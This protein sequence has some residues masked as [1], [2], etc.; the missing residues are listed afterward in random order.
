MR[1]LQTPTSLVHGGRM[2]ATSAETGPTAQS[3]E[4]RLV[5][6][7][8]RVLDATQL[9]QPDRVPIYMP[10]GNLL[11]KLEGV[12]QLELYENPDKAQA[13]LEKA[14]LRFQ[15]DLCDGLFGTP[16]LSRILGDRTTKW[17]GYGLGDDGSFQYHEAEYMKAE[18]YDAFLADPA[19]WGIRQYL[20]RVFSE[21]Q[22][23]GMLPP[24]GISLVGFFGMMQT[25]HVFSSPPVVS[26]FQSLFKAGQAQ[27]EWIQRQVTSF[28]RMASLGF[29][30]NLFFAGCNVSAPFDFMAD[31]LRGMKGIFTDMRR[32]PEKLLEA[33][34]KIIPLQL[35]FAIATCRQRHN[36]YAF[37]PLHRGSD[38]FISLANFE[39][40]Y[41]PQLKREILALIEAGITPFVLWEGAWDQRLQY[42][43]ELPKGKTIGFFQSTNL[44]H[45][46]DMLGDVMCIIG[47]MP[48][49]LLVGGAP[50]EIREHTH[51]MCETV[52]K[53]GGFVMMPTMGDLQG[54]NPDLIE[55]W[56]EATREYG[57][58]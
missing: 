54:S 43:A 12:S 36:P 53:G 10:F 13:A 56:A 25:A 35:E 45:A 42:L 47:G 41:W 14:A 17:P 19:D 58:Y 27:Y 30:P 21:L 20:P 24:L 33:E 9:R 23:F 40:F 22:G 11:S 31:S 26:A 5:E 39:R 34:E 55:V 16:E 6:R 49:G 57:T 15:P 46:K 8:K 32:S 2:T 18:D 28:Q 7:S 38:G 50:N 3:P 29:P 1:R 51:K 48:N 37:L 4:F 44:I 52:G